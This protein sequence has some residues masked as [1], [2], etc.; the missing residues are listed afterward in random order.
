MALQQYDGLVV[1]TTALIGIS[2]S[3]LGSPS[4]PAFSSVFSRLGKGF[5]CHQSHQYS[6]WEAK[7][8]LDLHPIIWKMTL[9]LLSWRT[10]ANFNNHVLRMITEGQSQ[11]HNFWVSCNSC[12]SCTTTSRGTTRLNFRFSLT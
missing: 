3:V 7:L 10:G 9:K 6:K 4:S 1:V 2:S 11:L 8:K 12:T 5:F